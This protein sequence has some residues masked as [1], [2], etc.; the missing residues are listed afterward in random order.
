MRRHFTLAD[1]MGHVA[2]GT[3]NYDIRP[4]E[5][6]S[7][8]FDSSSG[9]TSGLLFPMLFCISTGDGSIS[10]PGVVTY[11]YLEN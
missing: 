8:H 2:Q 5:Q 1:Y 7:R 6:W 10:C 9:H 11:A 3:C 4:L